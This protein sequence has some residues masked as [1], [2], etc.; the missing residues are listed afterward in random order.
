VSGFAEVPIFDEQNPIS[1]SPPKEGVPLQRKVIRT[2]VWSASW[3]GTVKIWSV[4]K[5]QIFVFCFILFF[6]SIFWLCSHR[7]PFSTGGTL[8]NY[9]LLKVLLQ[10]KVKIVHPFFSISYF[11]GVVYGATL[12]KIF[13][14]DSMGTLVASLIQ[15][16]ED[17]ITCLQPT[18][19]HIWA[20]SEKFISIVSQAKRDTVRSSLKHSLTHSPNIQFFL[21]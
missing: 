18:K 8:Q 19:E 15:E 16:G 4:E 13:A 9:P 3:D 21:F 20:G 12:Q 11:Q 2:T 17:S 10:E 14:W 6:C 1:L 5:V 7:N